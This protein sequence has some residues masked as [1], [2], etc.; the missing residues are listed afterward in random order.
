LHFVTAFK[1]QL[2]KILCCNISSNE[3]LPQDTYLEF[4]GLKEAKNI[5]LFLIYY[6]Q[7]FFPS[8]TTQQRDTQIKQRYQAGEGISALARVYGISPQRVF[9]ILN[10][11]PNSAQG[12]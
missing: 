11:K 9:Q 5:F 1:Y 8:L 7:D 6:Q 3:P 2:N 10:P 4:G 12:G